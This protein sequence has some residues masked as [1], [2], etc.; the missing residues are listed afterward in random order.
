MK[1]LKNLK[2]MVT[3]SKIAT[4]NEHFVSSST[5][6]RKVRHCN[7]SVLRYFT[8]SLDLLPNIFSSIVVGENNLVLWFQHL[9][10]NYK[11]RSS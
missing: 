2:E 9:L 10:F 6:L 4:Q 3:K 11:D 5:K 1:F 7:F 8:Q